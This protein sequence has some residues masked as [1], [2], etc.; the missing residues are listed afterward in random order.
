MEASRW[1]WA[2]TVFTSSND[3]PAEAEGQSEGANSIDQGSAQLDG[4]PTSGR[5]GLGVRGV[6]WEPTP[7]ARLGV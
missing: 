7:A 1:A 2:P 4:D 6:T 5:R 3:S